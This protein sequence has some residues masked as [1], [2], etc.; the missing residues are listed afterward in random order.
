MN[1]SQ[2]ANF[3]LFH[4]FK[5]A[6]ENSKFDEMVENTEEKG[7]IVHC[8]QFLLSHR[9]FRR[10]VRQTHKNKGFSWKGFTFYQKTHFRLVQIGSI[11]SQQNK[12]G[13][14]KEFWLGKCGK[15]CWKRRKCWLPAFSHDVF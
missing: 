4:A 12:C 1:S 5:F 10:F 3:R 9:V 15:H 7:E 13:S 6:D 11:C 8:E 2:T 14:E